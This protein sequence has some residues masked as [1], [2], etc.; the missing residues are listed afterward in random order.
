VTQASCTEKHHILLCKDTDI[1]RFVVCACMCKCLPVFFT[2]IFY[3]AWNKIDIMMA[4][5]VDMCLNC[6][7]GITCFQKFFSYPEMQPL[8]KHFC[9]CHV[10][11]PGQRDNAPLINI[12]WYIIQ[13]FSEYAFHYDS[14]GLVY[15]NLLLAK[16]NC[17]WFMESSTVL[18]M[19]KFVLLLSSN[20]CAVMKQWNFVDI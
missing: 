10:S 16:C 8:L 17:L 3:V 15:G 9:V 20:L 11:A 19:V 7:V 1:D 5:V 13:S 2:F 4:V 14:D 12:G 6:V 18:F